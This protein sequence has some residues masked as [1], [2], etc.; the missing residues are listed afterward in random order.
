MLARDYVMEA[1]TR[2]AVRSVVDLGCGD[3]GLLSTLPA[4]LAAWGYDLTPANIAAATER[5]VDARYE[6]I[7]AADP[8]WADLVVATEV[9]EHLED[10]AAL[11]QR[12]A[13]RS[14]IL[15]ASSPATETDRAHY[16]HHLWAFDLQGYR[17]LIERAGWRVI[18]HERASWFQVVMAICV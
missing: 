2:Y 5:G 3:G 18:R 9:L 1:R 6:D 12:A 4:D 13:Q 17:D 7:V 10:P 11:L 14:R 15:V 8:E 16:E